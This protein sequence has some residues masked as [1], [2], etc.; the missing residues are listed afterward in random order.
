MELN[1]PVRLGFQANR[2]SFL[3]NENFDFNDSA[4]SCGALNLL[5]LLSDPRTRLLDID[6]TRL[7]NLGHDA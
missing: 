4:S 2:L 3:A 7:W 5:V 6:P 1:E